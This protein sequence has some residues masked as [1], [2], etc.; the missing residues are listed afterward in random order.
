MNTC[1]LLRRAG[2]AVAVVFPAVAG[3]QSQSA[4]GPELS[5]GAKPMRGLDQSHRQSRANRPQGGDLPQFGSDGML[6][7]LRQQ[8]APGLLA[9]GLQHIQLL[10]ELLGAATGASLGDIYQ[11]LADM[12]GISHLTACRV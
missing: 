10:I 5:L 6:A 7:T 11:A 1:F 2:L 4:I 3:F 8:F 12:A 9:Q